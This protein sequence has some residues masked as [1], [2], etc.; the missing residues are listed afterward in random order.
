M[1]V[2]V[3]IRFLNSSNLCCNASLKFSEVI[4]FFVYP[5]FDFL[6]PS[7]AHLFFLRIRDQAFLFGIIFSFAS[8]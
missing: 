5:Q 1:F 7:M 6:Y 4:L 8:S 2:E 3:R